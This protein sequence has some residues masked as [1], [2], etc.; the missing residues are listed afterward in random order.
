[1]CC[2]IIDQL[3]A[4]VA[5][6]EMPGVLCVCLCLELAPTNPTA[7]IKQ[8]S[9]EG[10]NTDQ[11]KNNERK[12]KYKYKQMCVCLCLELAPTN[13]TALIKQTNMEEIQTNAKTMR[14]TI[15]NTNKC[16]GQSRN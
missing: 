10:G 8:T 6:T 2:C 1:M 13:P 5:E 4:I 12:Y 7:L 11:G 15:T 3:S 14:E 16:E 9:V